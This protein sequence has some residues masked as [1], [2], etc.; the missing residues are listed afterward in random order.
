MSKE[1][2]RIGIIS[3]D[4]CKKIL[5]SYHYLSSISKGFKSGVNFGL[6]D[7]NDAVVGVCIYTALP[8]PELVKGMFGLDRKEQEGMFELSRLCLHPDTQAKEYNITSWFV[9]RTIKMLRKQQKVRAILS[10][11]DSNY[12]KGTIYRATNFKYYGTTEPKKDFWFLQPDGTYVKHVRG[13]VKGKAG[14]WRP[15]SDKHRYLLV[16]DKSLQVLWE[17]KN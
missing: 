7:E 13:S 15:R 2:Y 6:Y 16:F 4:E 5:Q 14:E 8:V 9:A 1:Q 3:R 17:L 10:Y 12:H 11:A